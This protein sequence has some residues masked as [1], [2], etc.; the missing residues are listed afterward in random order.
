MII[1]PTAFL[2]PQTQILAAQP[3]KERKGLEVR[4]RKR[5][6]GL[7]RQDEQVGRESEKQDQECGFGLPPRPATI[8][9][10]EGERPGEGS[11]ERTGERV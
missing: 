1:Y 6:P 10:L 7:M 5:E 4:G 11:M 8:P 3:K 2:R 9:L